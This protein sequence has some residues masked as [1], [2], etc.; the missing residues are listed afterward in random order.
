V[1][2]I[3]IIIAVLLITVGLVGYSFASTEKRGT[4]LIPAYFGAALLM[5]G[6]LALKENLRKHAMHAAVIIGLAGFVAALVRPLMLL[7]RNETPQGLPF[8]MQLSMAVICAVF[9]GL[10][11]RSFIVTRRARKQEKDM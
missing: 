10:C 4:A 1:A 9:V 11:V 2:R 8:A 5:L 6:C 7:S 3:T